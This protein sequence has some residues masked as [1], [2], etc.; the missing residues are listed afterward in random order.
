MT[1]TCGHIAIGMI[2]TDAK[3]WNPD[4]LDHGIH[5]TWWSDPEQV[6]ARAQQNRRTMDLQARARA[7]RSCTDHHGSDC[8]NCQ[9]QFR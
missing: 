2:L 9:A 5:S 3:N 8:P 7:A 6:A 1:C 4:C